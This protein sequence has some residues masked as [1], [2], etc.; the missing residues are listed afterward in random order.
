MIKAIGTDIAQINR[1]LEKDEKFIL[2]I[3][4]KEELKIYCSF[5]SDE[6][7]VE[8]LAGRF[9]AKEALFK[10][11]NFNCEFN[12]IS[13]LNNEKG[14]PY[15]IMDTPYIIHISI[16]HEKDYVVTYVVVEE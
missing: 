7:K 5:T 11:L 10:A 8:Y 15:V 3:L 1:F 13:I 9:S 6:R 16:S 2:R 12:E 4:S 14:A